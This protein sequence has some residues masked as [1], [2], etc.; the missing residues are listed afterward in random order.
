MVFLLD[1]EEGETSLVAAIRELE[2]ET[3]LIASPEYLHEIPDVK[4][5]RLKMEEGF[6]D[7]TFQPF[8]CTRYEGELRSSEK[9]IPE[10]VKLNCLDGLNLVAD[11]VK[12]IARKWHNAS[13][14]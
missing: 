8:L 7:F 1:G 2:E 4:K 14:P 6:E 3:G 12:D 5:S 10:F 13:L 11:D 9:T